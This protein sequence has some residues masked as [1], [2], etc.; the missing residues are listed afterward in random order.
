MVAHPVFNFC[1]ICDSVRLEANNKA[2]VLGLY[3]VAPNV[4]IRVEHPN[5]IIGDLCFLLIS[6]RLT[7]LRPYQIGLSIKDP[8]GV[9]LFPIAEQ[10][11]TPIRAGTLSLGFE[12]RP[13]RLSGIGEYTIHLMVDNKLDFESSFTVSQASPGEIR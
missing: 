6:G 1:L 7:E 12:F 5:A 9:I 3:G 8:A 11:T 4:E 13:F 10:I 2:T